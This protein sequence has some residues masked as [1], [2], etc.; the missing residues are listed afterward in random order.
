M[1]QQQKILIVRFSSI[2]D[3]VLTTPVI[4]CLK[5]QLGATVHYLTKH[6][7]RPLLAENPYIDEIH[8]IHRSVREVAAN[9]KTE[10]Y[11]YIIDLHKNLRTWHLRVLLGFPKTYSFNKI[12]FEK[13][14]MVNFKINRLPDSHIVDRY[15]AT[16]NALGIENDGQGLDYFF[17]ATVN[18]MRAVDSY[19]NAKKFV[20]FAIGAT[21]ATKRMPKE[22]IIE[23]IQQLNMHVV[24][25]GG[26]DVAAEGVAIANAFDAGV[27][28]LCGQLNLH[29]SADC[30]RHSQWVITHDTGM[31]HI[32][33][34]LRKPMVSIWGNT[35]PAFGMYPYYPEGM[36]LNTVLEVEHLACR[37]CSKIGHHRCPKGH[38]KCM[39]DLDVSERLDGLFSGLKM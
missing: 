8:G 10:R 24:L 7:Y 26:K 38:F 36:Q 25:I 6:A 35:I 22:K 16:V 19:V 14:L 3:I 9:L 1:A 2:G 27:Q 33:A 20:V 28:N 34:A 21:H 23:L 5:L 13:W 17:P 11:D 37:P 4:R 12:N 15:L 32:A 39:H 18:A 29:E 31:M 30:I